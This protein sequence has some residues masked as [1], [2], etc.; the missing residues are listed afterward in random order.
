MNY[1]CSHPNRR[2]ASVKVYSLTVIGFDDVTAP[3]RHRCAKVGLR[4]STEESGHFIKA[5]E[6]VQDLGSSSLINVRESIDPA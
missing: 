4:G 2:P 6:T 5:P 1:V 3:R